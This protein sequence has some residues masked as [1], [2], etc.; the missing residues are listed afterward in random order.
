MKVQCCQ[1]LCK[2][3]IV[4]IISMVMINITMCEV[5]YVRPSESKNNQICLHYNPCHTLQYYL[6]NTTRYFK[7]NVQFYFL[8]GTHYLHKEIVISNAYNFSLTGSKQPSDSTLPLSLIFC[9]I[10]NHKNGIIFVNSCNIVIA[11]LQIVNCDSY[12]LTHTKLPIIN[13]PHDYEEE[14]KIAT[15]SLI[16][17]NCHSAILRNLMVSANARSGVLGVNLV[18]DSLITELNSIGLVLFYI[19]YTV[20]EVN[21]SVTIMN[22]YLVNRRNTVIEYPNVICIAKYH[23]NINIY[24]RSVSFYSS[25]H[26]ILGIILE[27]YGNAAI[28]FVKCYFTD[29]EFAPSMYYQEMVTINFSRSENDTQSNYFNMVHFIN[30]DFSQ[31]IINKFRFGILLNIFS[32]NSAHNKSHLYITN[33]TFHHNHRFKVL[34]ITTAS[35]D[36][37][38]H[39]L[40]LSL[41]IQNTSFFSLY[42]IENLIDLNNAFLILEGSVIF[43]E[44]NGKKVVNKDDSD[45]CGQI[46]YSS[47][48]NITVNGYLEVFGNT[49]IDKLFY[50]SYTDYITLNEYSVVNITENIVRSDLFFVIDRPVFNGYPLCFF[51]YY[52]TRSTSLLNYSIIINRNMCTKVFNIKIKTVHCK[53]LPDSVFST[54]MPYDVNSRII[55]ITS[56]TGERILLKETKFICYCTNDTHQDCSIDELGPVYPGQTLSVRFTFQIAYFIIKNVDPPSIPIQDFPF[57]VLS[58]N[59]YSHECG[60]LQGKETIQ[61]VGN[62]KC[63]TVNF[64]ILSS[65]D[66][67]CELFLMKYEVFIVGV[68]YDAFFVRLHACPIGFMLNNRMCVCDSVL[69]NGPVLVSM[70]DIDQQAILL[71]INSWISGSSINNSHQYLTSQHCPFDYCKCFPLYL[72]LSTPDVQC[73]FNRT[74]LLCGKCHSS[75]S[76][77]FGSSQCQKCSS[78]YLLIVIPL[79]LTGVLLVFLLFFLNLT[80]TNGDIIPFIFYANVVSMNSAIF[81]PTNVPNYPASA[82]I[83]LANLDLGISTCF[84]DGMDD[85]AKMWLTLVFPLYIILFTYLLNKFRLCFK[86]LHWLTADRYTHVIATLILLTYAKLLVAACH[87]LFFYTKIIQLPDHHS[88]MVWSVDANVKLFGV[89]F[90]C[91]FAF[92]LLVFVTII[93]LTIITLT[94]K[95]I[96]PIK[97]SLHVTPL[98]IALRAPYKD[99]FYYWPGFQFVL[100]TVFFGLSVT[101]KN[102]NLTIGIILLAALGY[103]HGLFSV[104][105]RSLKNYNEILYLLNL[106]VL[107]SLHTKDAHTIAVTILIG[108]AALQLFLTIVYHVIMF[109]F[110]AKI[111]EAL[112][113][114]S[115]IVVGK[116]IELINSNFFSHCK[117]PK[118]ALHKSVYSNSILCNSQYSSGKLY[119]LECIYLYTVLSQ[120]TMIINNQYITQLFEPL[121]I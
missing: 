50:F 35:G 55:Q 38:I 84:Y 106:A 86:K 14:L 25:H 7:S 93:A 100:R 19:E 113:Q 34:E 83:S 33:S 51:Q 66:N 62:D 109:S 54:K 49:F 85:Y 41:F 80:V 10:S 97:I 92:Y 20:A 107:F 101:N 91:L 46:I 58:T 121:T 88:T 57:T 56:L 115:A 114:Q 32:T 44:I 45:R 61:K 98:V 112:K 39:P 30:C 71:P 36:L 48:S 65:S 24:F 78:I 99:E 2:T 69:L 70:C 18:G 59:T 90:A 119:G 81:F 117:L 94:R 23:F 47:Q 28:Y 53:W 76:V 111:K 64:T 60:V 4:F 87:V 9:Q 12:T 26:K 104:F 40:T 52:A 73:Q 16:L 108:I 43:K 6:V 96:L 17:V 15:S 72:N 82:F 31:N 89:K 42:C 8:E 5:Y 95:V 105:K 102:I 116:I 37:Y 67:Q 11:N 63:T 68:T 27:N 103:L 118:H 74:G 75:H 110:H 1:F 21:S 22:F 77:V 120:P 79:A 3:T 13:L 29:N